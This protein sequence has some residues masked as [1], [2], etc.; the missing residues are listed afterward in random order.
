MMFEMAKLLLETNRIA[1][2]SVLS[3][4]RHLAIDMPAASVRIPHCRCLTSFLDLTHGTIKDLPQELIQN[5]PTGRYS[6]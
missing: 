4:S 1:L 6:I 3:S 5:L 2:M